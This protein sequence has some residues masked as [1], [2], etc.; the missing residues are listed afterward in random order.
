MEIKLDNYNIKH[1]IQTIAD[2]MESQLKED[3]QEYK[4]KIPKQHGKGQIKGYKFRDGISVFLIDGSFKEE[5]RLHISPDQ[6]HPIHF[7]FCT[8][9][10]FRHSLGSNGQ[11]K[12]SSYQ[13]NPLSGSI[14]SNPNNCE[15]QILFPAGAG[16][17][18]TNV[19]ISRRDYVRKE[20]CNLEKMPERLRKV[21]EDLDSEEMFIYESNYNIPTADCIQK[22]ANNS[23]EG[24]V[25]SSFCE[26]KALELLSLQLKQFADD[27]DPESRFTAL[28]KYDIDRIQQARKILVADLR[29]APTIPELARQAGINQQKLKQGFKEVYGKTIFQYLTDARMESARY[30][31]LDNSITV[32]EVAEHHG[33]SNQSHF[34]KRFKERY[35]ISPKHANNLPHVK[36]YL[37]NSE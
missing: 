17:L 4:V 5:F 2:Q 20:Q 26:A 14:T 9:G 33:Y 29:N 16:I 13:L 7:H 28:K 21:F 35:G 31:L 36:N 34:A 3:C 27:I 8:E 37:N 19:Q 25:R 22:L 18:H 30:M 6:I 12:F 23:Y 24:L 11:S 1:W 32:R 10:D 15:Q